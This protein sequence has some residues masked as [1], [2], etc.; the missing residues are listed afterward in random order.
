VTGAEWA[1]AVAAALPE[2]ARGLVNALAVEP[3]RAGPQEQE[4]YADAILARMQEIVLSRQLAA[5]KSKLQRMNPLEEADDHAR[6]FGELVALE[7]QRRV[8][9]DRAIGGDAG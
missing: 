4:R 6:L 8:L 3:L 9:R 2:E 5:L 7:A 1:A